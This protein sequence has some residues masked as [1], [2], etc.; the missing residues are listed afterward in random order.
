MFCVNDGVCCFLNVL[1]S[2]ENIYLEYEIEV[3]MV[4]VVLIDYLLL[5]NL[6]LRILDI[7]VSFGFKVMVDIGKKIKEC[8]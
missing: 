8:R 2:L 6:F 5:L 7:N 4:F 3:K 1:L